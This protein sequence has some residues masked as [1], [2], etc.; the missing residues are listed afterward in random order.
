MRQFFSLLIIACAHL[1]SA[2]GT[3]SAGWISIRLEQK[4]G[5]ETKVVPQ[6]TVFHTGDVLRFRI[7]SKT[8]GYLTVVD[9]GTSGETSTLFPG[10]ADAQSANL[11]LGEVR[12]VPTEGD[13]WFEVSGPTG[14]DVLYFMVTATPLAQASEK[15]SDGQRPSSSPVPAEKAIPK[16]LLPRCDDEIFKARGDC[17]DKAAGVTPLGADAPLPTQLK[18]YS[19]MATRDI[20][21]SED[22]DGAAVRPLPTA[23][24]PLIYSFRLA[25]VQ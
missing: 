24:L 12:S 8:T 19:R 21:V 17:I 3:Q 2:Q 1:L 6:N 9:V 14:Y 25:H 4:R 16:Q 18:P 13:G 15:P 23:K 11:R 10:S 22:E 5:S 7:T 20:I